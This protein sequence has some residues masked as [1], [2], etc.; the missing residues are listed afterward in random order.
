VSV[1]MCVSAFFLDRVPDRNLFLLA[2]TDAK[3]T[4]SYRIV[5]GL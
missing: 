4:F 5:C 2:E 3:F 1:C